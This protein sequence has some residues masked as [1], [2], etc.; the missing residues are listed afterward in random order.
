LLEYFLAG[1]KVDVRIGN[2]VLLVPSRRWFKDVWFA[3]WLSG[4]SDAIVWS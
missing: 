2:K 3:S 4:S 1:Y